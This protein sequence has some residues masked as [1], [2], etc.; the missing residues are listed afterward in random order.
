MER[1]RRRRACWNCRQV[2]DVDR[3]L[4]RPAAFRRK[5]EKLGKSWEAFEAEVVSTIPLNRWCSPEDVAGAVVWL[6]GPDT[7][8]VT[9]EMINVTGGFQAYSPTPA[10]DGVREAAE[11]GP[12]K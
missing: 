1:H 4:D 9:G 5:A 7:A 8:F 6:M 11:R 2:G 10:A 12:G 3:E